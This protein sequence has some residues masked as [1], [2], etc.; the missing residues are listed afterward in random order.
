MNFAELLNRARNGDAAAQ[1]E[2]IALTGRR[3]GANGMCVRAETLNEEKRQFRVTMT[4][5]RA[6]PM[7]DWDLWQ[8]IPEVL[9]ADGM[10]APSSVPL[11]D[12]HAR[13]SIDGILGSVTDFAVENEAVSGLATVAGTDDGT[14]AMTLIR[15]GHLTDVSVGYEVLEKTLIP[16]GSKGVVGGKNYDGPVN[17]V[18][19]WRLKELS[20][21]PIGAD[22]NAKIRAAIAEG[23]NSANAVNSKKELLMKFK[24]K[25][26]RELTLAEIDAERT[27][28]KD[29]VLEDG[30]VLKAFENRAAAAA[31]T[32]VVP[33][34]APAAAVVE[35]DA[36]KERKSGADAEFERQSEIR[37]YGVMAGL[38]A[39]EI[40]KAIAEREAAD[41]FR[42]RALKA[43]SERNKPV[44]GVT[45][46][47]A[48]H[49]IETLAPA[50][51][52]AI[53]LRCGIVND[54]GVA[55]GAAGRD[56]EGDGNDHAV[57]VHDRAREFRGLSLREMGR[58]FLHAAGVRAVGLTDDQL[59]RALAGQRSA[60]NTTGDFT[61]ALENTMNKIMAITYNVT[62]SSWRRIA[63]VTSAN[64]LRQHNLYKDGTSFEDFVQVPES[65]ELPH[66]KK[67][68]VLK[69]LLTPYT[70]GRQFAFT[71]DIIINDDM[72]FFSRI[73]ADIGAAAQRTVNRHAWYPILANATLNEDST[74]LFDSSTH[75]NLTTGGSSPPS[76]TTLDTM[77]GK[78]LVQTNQSGESIVV[79][80]TILA[81][82]PALRS[83][84]LQLLNSEY[85]P[86]ANNN[87]RNIY[88]GNLEP[89]IEPLLQLGVT[90]KNADGSSS[91]A[92]GS[93]TAYFLFSSP[94]DLP[95]VW[96]MFYGS[97][98][99]TLR[100]D[101][102]VGILGT[103]YDASIRFGKTAFEFRGTQKHTGAA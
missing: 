32:L 79:T 91:T 96:V 30:T 88:A 67:G 38:D 86:G 8:M 48:D 25:D 80:P 81:V 77:F 31:A 53:L 11:L 57:K 21:V 100:S 64:D 13:C 16:S 52:D 29:V 4:T 6:V 44:Q 41:A 87:E 62:P 9:R 85:V 73:P 19:K 14:K 35:I 63:R 102:P 10:E 36:D 50:V 90:I 37:Q 28:G 76:K 33:A 20:L 70:F 61:T 45:R 59:L 93:S 66:G 68:D 34:A 22:A 92:S 89:L 65:G 5:E 72:G 95:V 2:L 43:F 23:F 94:S 54:K 99:P 71:D 40:E 46:A 69:E 15:G 17:V 74:A 75:G 18:T 27:A 97:D 101:R 49:N 58:V 7:F 1:A 55:R 24:L 42:K 12:A 51:S 98:V 26:G 83:T 3:D 47:G 82:P 60:M 103:R 84:T 56:G 39:A 78:A